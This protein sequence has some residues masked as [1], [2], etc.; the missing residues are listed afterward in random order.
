MALID[1][2]FFNRCAGSF[3]NGQSPAYCRLKLY[4]DISITV[5]AGA[6]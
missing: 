6:S 1:K 2:T 3:D 5:S 4:S